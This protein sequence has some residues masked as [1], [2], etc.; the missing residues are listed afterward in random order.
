MINNV[1]LAS[2]WCLSSTESA[3][4]AGDHVQC[5]RHGFSPP[6]G[7]DPLEKEMA[8]H[9]SILA[10]E[11]P[12]TEKSGRLQ[13]MGLQESGHDLVSK[14]PPYSKVIQLFIYTYLFL[15]KFFSHLSCYIIE[16]PVLFS[17]SLLV[18]HFIAVLNIFINTHVQEFI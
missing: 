17:R 5:R 13:S 4:H 16:F 8:T 6:G 1:V 9:S 11:I 14:P 18:T 10:W 7:E 15:F 12:R 3:H 2:L